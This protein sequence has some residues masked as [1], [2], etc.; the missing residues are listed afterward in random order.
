[1][2]NKK[3]NK[4]IRDI[5]NILNILE[6]E[7]ITNF[8]FEEEEIIYKVL[9]K[10]EKKLHKKID[11]KVFSRNYKC[12]LRNYNLNSLELENLLEDR[13]EKSKLD[14]DIEFLNFYGFFYEYCEILTG[15]QFKIEDKINQVVEVFNDF[16]KDVNKSSLGTYLG[17]DRG[18][19][20]TTVAAIY[21][22]FKILKGESN[23]LDYIN[24]ENY[25]VTYV[26]HSL[27]NSNE[28]KKYVEQMLS[29]LNINKDLINKVN[30]LGI[31]KVEGGFRTD[32]IIFDDIKSQT[33]QFTEIQ[34]YLVEESKREII[35]H[36]SPKS[37]WIGVY[38]DLY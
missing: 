1:M 13:R 23:L 3:L 2:K 14:R 20:K 29:K 6:M 15:T 7:S 28:I 4:K 11:D 5:D 12:L 26:S 30:F 25:I 32:C 8:T 16:D 31:N 21:I 24:K 35:N 37:K 10:Q 9:A 19:G 34:R 27:S 36:L 18:D 22:V 17:F 38:S 33:N